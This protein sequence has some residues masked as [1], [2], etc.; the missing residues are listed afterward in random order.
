MALEIERRFIVE[1][2]EWKSCASKPKSIKQGYFST[3]FEEWIIRIRIINNEKSIIT[4]KALANLFTN[5]EFEYSIPIEDALSIWDGMS[6]K[7]IKQRYK[8]N[9]GEKG[10]WI[11]DCYEGDNYPLVVAEVELDSEKEIIEKPSWCNLEITGIKKLSNAGLANNPISSWT[12][13]ELKKINL[14]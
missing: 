10:E 5:K 12:Q 14:A 7:V 4:F 13:E 3:N 1:G 8:L 6:K 9:Y 11:I 2:N